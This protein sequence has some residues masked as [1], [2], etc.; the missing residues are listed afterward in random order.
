MNQDIIE[1]LQESNF[2]EGV[3]DSQSLDDAVLAW[4][5]C[6]AQP[7]LTEVVIRETHKIL[8]KNQKIWEEDKGR[9]RS[10]MVYIGGKA[11]LNAVHIS[12]EIQKWCRKMKRL[13]A[14]W[15]GMHVAYEKIHPF[16]DGNGR[17]GRIFMNW[18]R[19]R[20]GLSTLIIKE[21]EKYQYYQWFDTTDSK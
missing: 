4:E 18:H 6:I 1:F 19:A 14:D 7:K 15:K 3:V 8:M 9:Y 20:L 5:F 12:G 13:P 16:I 11:A 21:L 2:I 17:T 10:I